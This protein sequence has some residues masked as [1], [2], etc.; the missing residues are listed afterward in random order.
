M[1][2]ADREPKTF[3]E[4]RKADKEATQIMVDCDKAIKLGLKLNDAFV[5]AY[6]KRFIYSHA[7]MGSIRH[8]KDGQWWNFCSSQKLADKIRLLTYAQVRWS[9]NSLVEQ[10]VLLRRDD[11]NEASYDK[12][13]WYCI[14]GYL[15]DEVP[16]KGIASGTNGKA[17]HNGGVPRTNGSAKR[18]A[19][20]K[21][22]ALIKTMSLEGSPS[23]KGGGSPV[24]D[25]L[26]PVTEEGVLP[27]TDQYHI[28]QDSYSTALEEKIK[29]RKEN[30]S[31]LSIT[32][33]NTVGTEEPKESIS[34][35]EGSEGVV[36]ETPVPASVSEVQAV[37]VGNKE[38]I[39]GTGSDVPALKDSGSRSDN[40]SSAL[41]LNDSV[42]AL[43]VPASA[44]SKKPAAQTVQV[45]VQVPAVPEVPAV[46]PLHAEFY[47]TLT[48]KDKSSK[49][50]YKIAWTR[51][52]DEKS[53]KAAKDRA[54]RKEWVAS[55]NARLEALQKE[56]AS[57]KKACP[58]ETWKYD[59]LR[60][61]A[62][63]NWQADVRQGA[64]RKVDSWPRRY[65]G[66]VYDREERLD[67]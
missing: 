23:D 45:P 6:Q 9:L 11:L 62:W 13:Y 1:D 30:L 37:P 57:F 17:R 44:L 46:D 67:A 38:S 50:L 31:N 29:N 65:F 27:V 32:N 4:C 14:P 33:Q 18:K 16:G 64:E 43:Q 41:G 60:H 39:S 34:G 49:V 40:P 5:L 55:A 63:V 54:E 61:Y 8:F 52:L 10:G 35:T 47:K 51:F 53:G 58:S 19:K 36:S 21:G 3:A 56:I 59:T 2:N 28:V 48:D 20:A 26:L 7:S 22:K 12:T 66:R 15:T 25:P 24:T 42:A